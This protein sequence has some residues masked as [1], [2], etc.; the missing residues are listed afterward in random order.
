M[1][2]A[3][4]W[5]GPCRGSPDRPAPRSWCPRRTWRPVRR[6]DGG[7]GN[8]GRGDGQLCGKAR[9]HRS[10]PPGSPDRSHGLPAADLRRH[11]STGA[12]R[13][14]GDIPRDWR[15]GLGCG[16]GQED[17][18][19]PGAGERPGLCQPRWP[20]ARRFH[21]EGAYPLGHGGLDA[22]PGDPHGTHDRHPRRCRLLPGG[23]RDR[24]VGPFFA[25][26]AHGSG[27]G[28]A[29]R[30]DAPEGGPPGHRYLL[31]PLVPLPG[32]GPRAQPDPRLGPAADP[33]GPR[34]DR[35]RLETLPHQETCKPTSPVFLSRR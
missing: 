11:R 8:G 5:R 2:P 18:R 33:S 13:R 16:H 14:R 35:P 25:G 12:I 4:G 17:P 24:P 3:A 7:R 30:G 31:E 6:R 28:I 19:P 23:K 34:R 22:E 20:V 26:E 1:A 15:D 32:H 9:R 29:H 27:H 10:L 21:G